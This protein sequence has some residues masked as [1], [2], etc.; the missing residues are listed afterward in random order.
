MRNLIRI[1]S[2]FIFAYLSLNQIDLIGQTA[3]VSAED[4]VI[5]DNE[6]RMINFTISGV[7][8]D[9][10]SAMTQGL[11]SIRID[12]T[13]QNVG[14]LEIFLTSP[15]GQRIQLI[16]PVTG[17]FT[18]DGFFWDITFIPCGETPD[19]DPRISSGQY[20][21]N[22]EW[23]LFTRYSGL[24][25]PHIGCFED[26]NTG[27]VNGVWTL[28]II[29]VIR[30]DD[31]LI[32]Q[33]E[34]K[35]LDQDGLTFDLCQANAGMFLS[36]LNLQVCHFEDDLNLT[37][38]DIDGFT[39]P[40]EN[41][42]YNF[43]FIVA[44]FRS[45]D[46]IDVLL[47]P[48]L[49]GFDVADYTICGLSYNRADSVQIYDQLPGSN[50][51]ELRNFIEQVPAS[52]CADITEDCI[53]VETFLIPD[54]L[55]I[56]TT[57]CK[58]GEFVLRD[59]TGI[60]QIFNGPRENFIRKIGSEICD[61]I[62]IL[63]ITVSEV[64]AIISTDIDT[65]INCQTDT[66]TL[67]SSRSVTGSAPTRIWTTGGGEIVGDPTAAQIQITK[68]GMYNLEIFNDQGCS[69]NMTIEIGESFD[70]PEVSLLSLDTITC[71]NPSITI[72]V[73]SP[74]NIFNVLWEGPDYSSTD[75]NAIVTR[76]GMYIFTADFDN[77]CSY[78][79]SVEVIENFTVPQFSVDVI[80][81]DCKAQIVIQDTTIIPRGARWLT[82]DDEELAGLSPIVTESGIYRLVVASNLDS[83]CIDTIPKEI[84]FTPPV[85]NLVLM[86]D[87]LSCKDSVANISIEG[88]QNYDFI[89]WEG[90][91]IDAQGDSIQV[92][93]QGIFTV[94]TIDQ[95]N[96]PG[97][98]QFEV[99]IDSIPPAVTIDGRNFGCTEEEIILT[100]FS[101]EDV[102]ATIW[103]GPD[104]TSTGSQFTITNQGRYIAS[105]EGQNG[106]IGADTF[107][108]GREEP[109]EV[110]IVDN[111]FNCD[112]VPIQLM[113]SISLNL[114]DI[115]WIGPNGF[116]ST[117]Q[118][119]RIIDTGLY[120][121]SVTGAD[122]CIVVDSFFVDVKMPD[123]E[124]SGLDD[125]TINCSRDSVQLNPEVT[126]IFSSV[127]WSS[128]S[129][130]IFPVLDPF[131][132]EGGRYQLELEDDF[133]CRADTFIIVNVDTIKPFVNIIQSGALACES[134]EVIL[135]GEIEE[136]EDRIILWLDENGPLEFQEE[137]E[138]R[139]T[140]SGEYTLRIF[141][142]INACLS[143][144]QVQI[145]E[146]Q[147]SLI[148][149]ELLT[150]STC[151]NLDNG[152]VVVT[153]LVG[154]ES[155]FETSLDSIDFQMTDFYDNLTEG[156]YTIFARDMN[157]CV[158]A[159]DFSIN[160]NGIIDIEIGD[161]LERF[162][163][164][165]IEIVVDTAGLNISGID[166]FS[167]DQ[168]VSS[169]VDTLRLVGS[170]D[171]NIRVELMAKNGC[172]ATDDLD[173][174]IQTRRSEIYEPNTFLVG[175]GINGRFRIF[176][177]ATVQRINQFYI[178]DRWGNEMYG[179]ENISPD[180][181]FGWD[182]R[183]NDQF[184]EQGVYVY[185]SKITLESGAVEVLKG[186]LTLFRS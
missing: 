152:S 147:N 159:K 78:I 38:V 88:N 73:T 86:G 121:L 20:A 162:V 47:F 41:E 153:E 23:E 19:P 13:H 46:I 72:E 66:I 173:I 164:D 146:Q 2:A 26:I 100:V 165:D 40:W 79:D 25:H 62:L 138:Q 68:P 103:L 108:V 161:D 120:I 85:S 157:G 118:N 119:I 1:F 163:G 170:S 154:S 36:D 71:E 106:C 50:L 17:L 130:D 39:K 64:E 59:G 44:D 177:N 171:M 92:D 102:Q 186:T 184:A 30:F 84:F 172:T 10:L 51:S 43:E 82:S 129:M 55:R 21:N 76:G 114:D 136:D 18:T 54:T 81:I 101:T 180:E 99:M 123:I 111:I 141:N 45:G 83:Q 117:D 15:A 148:D 175:D 93:T 155:P 174:L 134:Q 77:G 3:C 80:P 115:N 12:F 142:P 94:R 132:K 5:V 126:G 75:M 22:L 109:F 131:V 110:S 116:S 149:I 67:G 56:D 87:Q 124:I 151:Q 33:V 42:E 70:I 4:I 140:E 168:V 182:G 28:E 185:F 112:L 166:W 48:D 7:Q 49:R 96:C 105:L 178:Y 125:L 143:Q 150:N 127:V 31:G 145:N 167:D 32:N 90:P 6:T 144:D 60:A 52:V 57:I 29:D 158:L 61:S 35:F 65:I 34:I 69:D 16:G 74:E 95:E 133:G 169:D 14:N 11:Q 63:N 24:Y 104:G 8:N 122:Q 137:L 176:T 160:S 98:G 97:I 107:I 179:I 128:E 181:D 91:G 27:P 53:K 183:T 9:D 58:N 135:R 156:D 89:F 37:Q 139:I 113:S